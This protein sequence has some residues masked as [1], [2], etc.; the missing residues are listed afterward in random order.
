MPAAKYT[1]ISITDRLAQ[2]GA[3]PSIGTV[4]D[5]LDNALAETTIGLYKAELI[6]KRGPWHGINH[7][8]LSTLEYVDWCN[9]RRIHESCDELTPAETEEVYYRHHLAARAAAPTS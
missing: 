2:A 5:A 9:H 6:D 4:G 1:S 7:I 8:E 3:R